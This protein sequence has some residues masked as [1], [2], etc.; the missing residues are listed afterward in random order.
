[1]PRLKGILDHALQSMP[2]KPVV[3]IGRGDYIVVGDT[4][5]YPQVS[6][7]A[8]SLRE[9]LGVATIVFLGDYV[10]RGPHGLEN[11]E[12]VLEEYLT[13]G[14]VLLRGNHE[15]PY[16]N[17]RYGFYD[18]LRE[19]GKTS[20]F[21]DIIQLY[22][23]LPYIAVDNGNGVIMLHGGIPCR[24][25]TQSLEKPYTI[26]EASREIEEARRRGADVDPI[27][28]SAFHILWN[29]PH[30]AIE[31]FAPSIRGAY[32]YGRA[33]WSSFLEVNGGKVLVRAHEVADAAFTWTRRG[34]RVEGLPGGAE[35][36]WRV[37]EGSVVTVFSSLYHAGRAGILV[38]GEKGVRLYTTRG[39]SLSP[40]PAS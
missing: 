30:G 4:H 3:E 13:G 35:A 23:T 9:K 14:V 26:E 32:Y 36:S 5:G 19:K 18:E 28:G 6:R 39:S 24:R 22:R 40:E 34:E 33:A 20:L 2:S 10:D 8:L 12:V 15:S 17:E 21:E 38:V 16:M 25:C 11:L 37:L 7:L 29:D 1:M 27:E 31:W